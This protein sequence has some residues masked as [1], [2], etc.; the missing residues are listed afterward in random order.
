[1]YFETTSGWRMIDWY[2][3]ES[4]N[5]LEDAWM[6]Y[7]ILATVFENQEFTNL[8]SVQNK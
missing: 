7:S 5:S 2:V 3:C 8:D 1:M 6:L 4:K